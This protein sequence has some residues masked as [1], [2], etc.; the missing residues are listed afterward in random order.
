M[1]GQPQTIKIEFGKLLVG[2]PGTFRMW[3]LAT[4]TQSCKFLDEFVGIED[5][6]QDNFVESIDFVTRLF[7]LW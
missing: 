2:L 3:D 6:F 5:S 4:I 1:P 7:Q